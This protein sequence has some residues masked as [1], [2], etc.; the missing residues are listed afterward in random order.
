MIVKQGDSAN[1]SNDE[2]DTIIT[3]G[4]NLTE[5]EGFVAK[6]VS[7]SSIIVQQVCLLLF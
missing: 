7:N 3:D 2:T 1:V 4:G 5:E 6:P